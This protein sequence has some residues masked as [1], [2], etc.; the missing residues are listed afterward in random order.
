MQSSHTA[1][2][3]ATYVHHLTQDPCGGRV[4]A[5]HPPHI[6]FTALAHGGCHTT[7]SFHW[8]VIRSCWYVTLPSISP[9]LLY[10]LFFP[11]FSSFSFTLCTSLFVAHT[12]YTSLPFSSSLICLLCVSTFTP[13]GIRYRSLISLP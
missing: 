7:H 11:F 9:P 1:A 13:Q 10:F 8:P 3:Y 5:G 4:G 12:F 6:R 2:R